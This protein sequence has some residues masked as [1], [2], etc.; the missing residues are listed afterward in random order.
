M[1]R[2]DTVG[3]GVFKPSILV[4]YYLANH[5]E[6]SDWIILPV[7]N[8]DCYFGD[9]NF[10]RKYLNQFPQ[11]VIERSDSFGISRYRV[12][13]DYLFYSSQMNCDILYIYI[14]LY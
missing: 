1:E 13:A 12:K 3:A 4:A 6:D 11:E 14:K 7:T 5:P 2:K 9:I 8:F 10:S